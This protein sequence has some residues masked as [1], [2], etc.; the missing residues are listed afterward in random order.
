MAKSRLSEHSEQV[1]LVRKLRGAKLLYCAVP[2]GGKRQRLDAVKLKAEGVKKG[3]PDLLIFDAPPNHP[4]CVGT[5]VEMK[6]E[7]GS[8]SDLSR[9][10]KQWAKDLEKRGWLV[11]VGFG[12][13]DAVSKLIDAG[14]SLK[15]FRLVTELPDTFK[16][17]LLSE[18]EGEA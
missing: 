9:H 4:D 11:L 3:V 1:L 16:S 12:A 14:Y 6:R 13:K 7:G 5:A 2:N 8:R 18:V 15:P 10:Q 17:K